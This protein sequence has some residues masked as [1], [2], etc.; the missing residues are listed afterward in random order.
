[1]EKYKAFCRGKIIDYRQTYMSTLGNLCHKCR[2]K[3]KIGC[4]SGKLAHQLL[5]RRWIFE[6]TIWWG[7]WYSTMIYWFTSEFLEDM[8][9]FKFVVVMIYCRYKFF[10][11]YFDVFIKSIMFLDNLEVK[12]E[13]KKIYRCWIN[14]I[15][16]RF[17][18]RAQFWT[19]I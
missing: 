5:A 16:T 7:N 12:K 17:W 13:R 4:W 14:S 8:E 3:I 9:W 11:S 15:V 19:K 10:I 18:H 2:N 6:T 1:M